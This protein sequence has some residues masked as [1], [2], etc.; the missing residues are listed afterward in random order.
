MNKLTLN[1]AEK[2]YSGKIK[3]LNETEIKELLAKDAKQYKG[4]EI[5]EIYSSL[6]AP[7]EDEPLGKKGI[8]L[9]FLDYEQLR[10]IPTKDDDGDT[11]LMPSETFKKYNELIESLPIY[12]HYTFY[13]FMASGH[14]RQTSKGKWILTGIQINKSQPV[15]STSITLAVAN[16]LNRQIDDRNNPPSNSRYYLL[17]K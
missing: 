10:A 13:Q 7:K 15:N 12:D 11:I 5:E 14:F 17:K 8:D 2:K 9:S 3:N 4:E 16:E 6:I 1:A